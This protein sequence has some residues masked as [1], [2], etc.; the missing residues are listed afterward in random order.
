MRLAVLTSGGKDSFFAFYVMASQGF[1]IRYLLSVVPETKESYMFHRPTIGLLKLQSEATGIELLTKNTLGKKEKELKDLKDI[2]SSVKIE[3]A[4]AGAVASEYQKQRIDVICE[5]LG[6]KSFVPIWHKDPKLL[7][8]EM[9]D[10]NFE[11]VITS[12]NAEGLD[13]S[14]L[15]RKIDEKC[16]HD[17]ISLNEK[18]GLH[19]SGEGGE[20]ETLVLDMPLFNKKLEILKAKKEWDGCS[21]AYIVE[22]ARLVD[23]L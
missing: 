20:Y 23:K 5:D 14:W 17:L 3:G 12:V 21:G 10:A 8:M 6:L 11:V 7:L 1:D 13:E 4:V 2:L 16:V 19:V 15:G 9:I 22:K 18:Y